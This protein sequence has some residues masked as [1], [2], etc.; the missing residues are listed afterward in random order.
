MQISCGVG[1][2][3]PSVILASRTPLVNDFSQPDFDDRA[4]LEFFKPGVQPRLVLLPEQNLADLGLG[5]HE[6]LA[7]EA[8][9]RLEP[10]DVV[11]ELGPVRLRDLPRLEGQDL[12]LDVLG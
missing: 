9:L 12:G 2:I 4:L 7:L 3:T 10:E 6:G 11:P 1:T 5:A 8:L